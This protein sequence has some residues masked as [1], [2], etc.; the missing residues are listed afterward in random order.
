[1]RSVAAAG[2]AGL[3]RLSLI[4]LENRPMLAENR[5]LALISLDDQAMADNLNKYA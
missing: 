2:M 5:R 3:Y 1:M 4:N